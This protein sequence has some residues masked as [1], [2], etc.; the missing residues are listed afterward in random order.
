MRDIFCAQPTRRFVH[1]FL[2]FGTEMQLWIFGR[3]GAYSSD[4]FDI[5]QQPDRYVRA[6]TRYT[7]MMDEEL[8]LDT[9]LKRDVQHPSVTLANAKTGADVTLP[10]SASPFII[11]RAI[12]SR[13][14]FC[15]RTAD[16]QHVVKFS[17]RSDKRRPEACY[18]KRS[19]GVKGIARS[20][21]S[22]DV[23]SVADLRREMNFPNCR[24]LGNTPYE[25]SAEPSKLS[26]TSQSTQE[27]ESLSLNC[28]KWKHG[29]RDGCVRKNSKS[30]GQRSNLHQE[31]QPYNFTELPQENLSTLPQREYK[32]RILTC[33][34]VSPAGRALKEFNSVGELLK[35]FRDAIK[36]HKSLYLNR[37]ILHRDVF[38]NNIILTDPK[39]TEGISGMLIDFDLAVTVEENGKLNVPRN[40][41]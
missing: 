23:I 27:L 41:P 22:S 8:G 40:R 37:K 10:A 19:Q 1:G 24:K 25:Q 38:L 6:I 4:T 29:S 9:F 12:V 2:F 17:W 18:L 36:A 26:F 28:A 5:L 35:G 34:A 31:I 15:Y 21:G 13:G 16:Q 39:Q 7:L 14:T 11:W 32:N 20:V 3:S 33:L 30:N